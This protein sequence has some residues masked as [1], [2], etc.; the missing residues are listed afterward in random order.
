M[1]NP[2]SDAETGWSFSY[3]TDHTGTKPEAGLTLIDVQHDGH[4]FA[5]DIRTIGLRIIVEEVHPP[6]IVVNRVSHFFF[7]DAP[8]FHVSDVQVLKPVA[9]KTRAAGQGQVFKYLQE[10]DEALY[11]KNYFK[12]GDNYVAFGL[13]A[14]FAWPSTFAAS[15]WPNAAFDGLSVTQIFLFSR[16]SGSPP[17]EPGD[18][19][20]AARCHPLINFGVTE[21]T[22]VDKTKKY[23]RIDSIRFDYYLR[24]FIDRHH[25]VK[26]NAGL[27]QIGNNAGLFRDREAAALSAAIVGTI[28]KLG[29]SGGVTEIAFGAVEKPLVL[30]VT[31]P[32]L[33]MGLSVFR[34]ATAVHRCWDNVHWWGSRGKGQPLISA[35]GAFHAAH[36]H[37]RWGRAGFEIR[38][39]IPEV[40][41]TGVPKAASG[42]PA[43][44][45]V[46]GALVDPRVWMQSI[47][48]GVVKHDKALDPDVQLSVDLCQL[49]WKTLF[50]KLR[51]SPSDI[52]AGDDIVLWYSVE[53]HR[54]L[55]LPST[56]PYKGTPP[57]AMA[58]QTFDWKG[59]G[60]VFLHGMFFAHDAEGGGLKAG[61]TTAEHRPNSAAAIRRAAQWFRTAE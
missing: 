34:D 50:T 6:E 57:P 2:V 61:T 21:N 7:L 60:T 38:P 39:T 55:V 18:V 3:R 59:G 36:V 27:P 24:L 49:D 16:Y 41:T 23:Y 47:R 26:T 22:K 52:E 11:L 35:P 4:N 29:P 1:N 10:A 25:V 43:F 31:A 32:G 42:H 17:H 44:A 9:P 12:D 58:A 45:G 56:W 5:K 48:I 51:A 28:K 37:W 20:S 15:K 40:D 54:Q 19:L 14:I 8:N 53:A 33:A 30:E 46:R 13:K